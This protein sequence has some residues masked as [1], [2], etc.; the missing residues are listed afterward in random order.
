MVGWSLVTAG[1]VCGAAAAVKGGLFE[2]L[3]AASL[4]FASAAGM[5][6]YTNKAAAPKQQ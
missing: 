2:A 3:T 1:G 4:A 5:C 6:G